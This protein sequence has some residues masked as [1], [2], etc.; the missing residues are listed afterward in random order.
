MLNNLLIVLANVATSVDTST[1]APVQAVASLSEK[2]L[3]SVQFLIIGMIAIFI[4]IACIVVAVNIVNWAI[5]KS[6]E[7]KK[8]NSDDNN[9]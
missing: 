5:A 3:Q 6:Q 9:N 7:P 1:S 2:L 4:V 8:Q